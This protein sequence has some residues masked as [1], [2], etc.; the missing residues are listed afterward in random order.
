MGKLWHCKVRKSGC[1]RV[2]V[3]A[4]VVVTMAAW[5]SMIDVVLRRPGGLVASDR[6]APKE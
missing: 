3:G 2:G 6:C 1:V 4:G 5:P